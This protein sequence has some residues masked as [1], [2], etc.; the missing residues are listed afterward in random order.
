MSHGH[1]A[2]TVRL[3]MDAQR[4]LSPFLSLRLQPVVVLPTSMV[5]LFLEFKHSDRSSEVCFHGDSKRSQA[6]PE[7]EL[8]AV[9]LCV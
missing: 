7:D 3:V 6:D 1:T 2:S 8:H 5:D 4:R 9:A